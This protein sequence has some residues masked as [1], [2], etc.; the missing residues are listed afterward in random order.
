MY[1]DH[2]LTALPSRAKSV[3][4]RPM[5]DDL[6]ESRTERLLSWN[7]PL[8]A[9][10]FQGLIEAGIALGEGFLYLYGPSLDWFSD[11][12]DSGWYELTGRKENL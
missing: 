10:A 1:G 4:R 9:Y 12:L 6:P 8:R 7:A 5:M 2:P 11:R 3:W